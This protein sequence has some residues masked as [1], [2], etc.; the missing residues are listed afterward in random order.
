MLGNT[1]NGQVAQAF[2]Y[3]VFIISIY[4]MYAWENMSSTCPLIQNDKR[5]S[6]SPQTAQL[7]VE[8]LQCW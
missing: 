2:T 5:S 7:K 1:E 6:I 8:A 4:W 3:G